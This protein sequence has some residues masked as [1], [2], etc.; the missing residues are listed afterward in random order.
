MQWPTGGKGNL[1][2]AG[3]LQGPGAPLADGQPLHGVVSSSNALYAAIRRPSLQVVAQQ[4]L[5][6]AMQ[7]VVCRRHGMTAPPGEVAR[8]PTVAPNAVESEQQCHPVL[9]LLP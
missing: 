8:R 2:L 3:A 4:L 5:P 9:A 7:L 6:C 1:R